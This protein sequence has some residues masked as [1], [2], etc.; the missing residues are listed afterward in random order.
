MVV[1]L[2]VEIRGH[3]LKGRQLFIWGLNILLGFFK[4]DRSLDNSSALLIFTLLNI[5]VWIS[6]H[7]KL[8]IA[9]RPTYLIWCAKLNDLR[10]FYEATHFTVCLHETLSFTHHLLKLINRHIII[11]FLLLRHYR[12]LSHLHVLSHILSTLA[13]IRGGQVN[14]WSFLSKN[15]FFNTIHLRYDFQPLHLLWWL[16]LFLIFFGSIVTQILIL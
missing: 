3:Y 5:F 11:I 8:L 9:G 4:I 12:I 16:T 2:G 10:R 7:P 1:V 14:S 15:L 6:K 13:K